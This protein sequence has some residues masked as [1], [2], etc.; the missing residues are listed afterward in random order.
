MIISIQNINKSNDVSTIDMSYWEVSDYNEN[1]IFSENDR[2]DSFRH[3]SFSN[4]KISVKKD[5]D[6]NFHVNISYLSQ[7]NSQ[8]D[9]INS[10]SNSEKIREKYN[11][12]NSSKDEY[13]KN[14][15]F[16]FRNNDINVIK[17]DE[18]SPSKEK[19]TDPNDMMSFLLDDSNF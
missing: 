19:K 7:K 17:S 2:H 14:N 12:Y 9:I 16:P 8:K 10:P 3:E 4:K 5:I 11:R 13:E 1:E 15:H 18:N 6:S